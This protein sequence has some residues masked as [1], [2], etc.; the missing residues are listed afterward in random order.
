MMAVSGLNPLLVKSIRYSLREMSQDDELII[1]QD[2][3]DDQ[4]S[5]TI[6]GFTDSRLRWIYR[7]NNLG[8]GE[9][10]REL[11]QAARG[12]FA[13]VMDSDDFALP[14]RFLIPARFL[15]HARTDYVFSNARI[16]QSNGIFRWSTPARGTPRD[17]AQALLFKNVL[18]HS[19]LTAKTEALQA[20]GYQGDYA[21]DYSHYLKAILGGFR[22]TLLR[23][24]LV[25]YNIHAG[26]AT[27]K[28]KSRSSS[29]V[30]QTLSEL[31]MDFW[32]NPTH[33]H[34]KQADDAWKLLRQTNP[35]LAAKVAGYR[36]LP[37][38]EFTPE[39]IFISE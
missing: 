38:K 3:A 30:A 26:Q 10:R 11:L 24:H 39:P 20:I 16:R 15:E 35:L 12:K 18:V 25:T 2:G 28:N 8:I 33:G 22:L 31:S 1:L 13:A 9:T 27:K 21:E 23:N 29:L 36:K 34:F 17:I 7:E 32:K 4:L 5:K 6:R 19:S 37:S 14:G